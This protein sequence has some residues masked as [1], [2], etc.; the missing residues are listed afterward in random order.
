VV[1][2]DQAFFFIL[3]SA[4]MIFTWC[5]RLSVAIVRYH[6]KVEWWPC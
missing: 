6:T 4:K 2:P 1:D 5:P 3:G